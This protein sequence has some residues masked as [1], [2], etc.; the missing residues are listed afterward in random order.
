MGT[1]G[2]MS[3]EQVRGEKLDARTD[4]FS[5]GLVLYEMATGQRAFSGDTAAIVH[6]AILNHTPA[7]GARPQFHTPAQAGRQSSTRRWRKT[8]NG[9]ISPP[10]TSAPNWKSSGSN[11]PGLVRRHWKLWATAAIV[12]A[13]VIG[14]I[15][16]WRSHRTAYLSEKDTIVLA[17]FANSTGDPVFD[18]TLKQA[19]AIQLGQSPFLN[20]LSDK[21][22]SDTLKLMQH[23]SAERLTQTTAQAVCLRANSRAVVEGSIAPMGDRYRI[24]LKAVDC[25]SGDTL[26]T[27]ETE[28]AD[29]KQVLSALAE[30]ANHLRQKL[31]ESRDSLQGFSTSAGRGHHILPRRIAG[32]YPRPK[33]TGG[34]GASGGHSLFQAG[35]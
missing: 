31:G 18:G 29:R 34:T 13:A 19:L 30:A 16:Y 20:V 6:D 2:Y 14:G 33:E 26:A 4:L 3:P 32:L 5:F 21:Q 11:Q 10:R 23:G 22:V 24:D 8:A 35:G 17:N 15:L 28:S 27:A 7:P 1:A 12:L 9:A 25:H